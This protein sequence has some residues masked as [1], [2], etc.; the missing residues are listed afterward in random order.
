MQQA[1]GIVTTWGGET[2][3]LD[4]FDGT[5]LAAANPSLHRACLEFLRDG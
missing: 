1:G 4:A 5:V 2:I 3:T